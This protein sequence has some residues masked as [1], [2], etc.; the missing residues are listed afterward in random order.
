M[1]TLG[2][3]T[4][5]DE[6]ACAL[7][8]DGRKILASQV[9]SQ[10]KFHRRFMGVVPE[11]ASRQHVRLLQP[12]L[13]RALAKARLRLK[14]CD[15]ISVTNGPGLAGALMVGVTMAKSLAQATGI[16]IVGV[17]HLKA[18]LEPCFL[19]G[20]Q[21]ALKFPFIGLVVS[22]GHTAL[23]KARAVDLY[24][25]IAETRDDAAGEAFDKAAK[26]LGLGFPGGPRIERWAGKG[27][28]GRVRLPNLSSDLGLDFSYSG[29]KTAVL[30][31]AK[32]HGLAADKRRAGKVQHVRDLCAAFQKTVV[33][34]LVTRAVAACALRRVPRL[35]VGGG[36]A[37]N[38]AL[39]R[40]LAEACNERGIKLFYPRR[41]HTTDNA[42]MVALR[43]FR[44]FKERGPDALD[45]ACDPALAFCGEG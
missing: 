27:D 18:H 24:E 10:I 40:S 43:G 42:V 44:L 9:A 17:N 16:P 8:E 39:E 32:K 11:I 14:D 25:L 21:R 20:G 31:Y 45:L 3:E 12:V 38:R 28:P 19:N 22:G 15:L 4:S 35:A 23:V 41:E 37:A 26:I 5:C 30:Y 34:S 36:V 6:T 2:I 13:E 29:L 7:V 1:I 33:M